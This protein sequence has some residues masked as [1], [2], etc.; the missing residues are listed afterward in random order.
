MSGAASGPARH[1]HVAEPEQSTLSTRRCPAVGKS[2]VVSAVTMNAET[3]T[4][5]TFL[6][7]SAKDQA[8]VCPLPVAASRQSAAPLAERL[9]REQEDGG[10]LP[11][12]RYA[13]GFRIA[14]LRRPACRQMRSTRTGRSWRPARFG[15][16]KSGNL[17]T[18]AQPLLRRQSVPAK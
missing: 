10:A 9:A 4:H 15:Y 12:R 11:R 7:H 17:E 6:S 3:F 18:I 16:A 5:G 8:V 14:D 13:F 1:A 2:R